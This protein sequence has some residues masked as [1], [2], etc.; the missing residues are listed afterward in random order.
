MGSF[1]RT[2]NERKQFKKL[3]LSSITHTGRQYFYVSSL[4]EAPTR[5]INL[6]KTVKAHKRFIG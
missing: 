3:S 2:T 6:A 1:S 4:L 5:H